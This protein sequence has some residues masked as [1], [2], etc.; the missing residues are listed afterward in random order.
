MEAP[1]Q[2]LHA[3]L[4]A[5]TASTPDR[6]ALVS[7]RDRLTYRQLAARTHTAAAWLR[8]RGVRRGDRVLLVAANSADLVCAVYATSRLGAA[9]V[10]VNNE[11]KP[12][13][14]SHILRDAEPALVLT[15]DPARIPA[16]PAVPV[17]ELAALPAAEPA[18]EPVRWPG[19]STDVACL[20]YTSGSTAAPKGVVSPHRTMRFA[21][22]AI[23]GRLDLRGDDVIGTYL[24]LSFDYALYQIFL[25]ARAGATLA[26]GDPGQVGPGLLSRLERWRVTVLPLVPSLAG[27]LLR[28]ARR[29]GATRLSALRSVTNTGARLA[30]ETI[31]ALR[32]QFP[33]VAVY[34]M[35]G[36]TECKR[37]AILD[38]A[39]LDTRRGSVGRPLPDTEC[40]VVDGDGRVL[41]P[42]ETGEL[43]VR[44]PHV[45]A[46]YWRAPEQTARRFRPFGSGT[47]R[48][49]FTGD[50]CA[51]DEDGYLYFR[52]RFD[53]VYK[54][55]GH[56]VSTLEV[57]AAAL[58]VP[59]VAEA[60]VVPP[61]DDAEGARLFVTGT[62]DSGAVLA[63]LRER[64]EPAKVPDSVRVLDRLPLSTNRKVDR[65]RLREIAVEVP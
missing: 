14:L 52:G 12:F 20:I 25:A 53:D 3:L 43:V 32:D 49:L 31:D 30:P 39:E 36:L 8:E 7:D 29:D 50:M 6:L 45:M 28:L 19:I 63:G 58:H 38:P 21:V 51:L 54:S 42:G 23:A 22:D 46:G 4:D 18:A 62:A 65:D 61:A 9:F 41:P 40:L 2:S 55:R 15:D 60:A 5:A 16:E 1:Q 10:V 35:F 33:G 57:E 24:P 56:R 59:G 47:E 11:T 44:G 13:H 48:A 37:V 17:A 64:L 27:A 34:A 26:L